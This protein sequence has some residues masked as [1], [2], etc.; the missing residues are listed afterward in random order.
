MLGIHLISLWL[1]NALCP[2]GSQWMN[3]FEMGAWAGTPA[4]TLSPSP[5]PESQ[6]SAPSF[7]KWSENLPP[8]IK[9]GILE[10]REVFS[11]AQLGDEES[12]SGS[13]TSPAR[14]YQFRTAILIRAGLRLTHHVL[15]DYES[16]KNMISY[17]DAKRTNYNAKSKVLHLVGGIWG[18]TL[19]SDILFQE[20]TDQWIEYEFINGHFKGLKGSYVFEPYGEKGTV[21]FMTGSLKGKKWPPKFV[22]ERG[23]EIVFGFTAKKMRSYVEEQKYQK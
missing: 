9:K 22:I 3:R 10:N 16:Y 5:V 17:I 2:V 13:E 18:W 21:V 6:K 15:T 8:K 19:V 11:I 12:E 20:H 7:E 14:T 1:F 23:A 4:P